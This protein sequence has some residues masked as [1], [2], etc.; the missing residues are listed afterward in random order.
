[1][2]IRLTLLF[3]LF[4]CS[5]QLLFSQEVKPEIVLTEA[6]WKKYA[7]I[8]VLTSTFLS[9]KEEELK[10]WVKAKEELG[11]GARF[12]QIKSVWGNAKK[13]TGIE[14]TEK[15]RLAYQEYLTFQDSLQK[16]VVA[17]QAELI[18]DE[19]VLGLELFE[20]LSKIIRDDPS[21]KEKLVQEVA[22]LKKK[23]K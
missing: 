23:A 17:Y 1:M 16:L 4:L 2:R 12:N 13:E 14:L 11:G 9:Q 3:L 10:T 21:Q 20:Q 15:E 22:R 7:Q 5:G 18:R 8:E 6:D 19:K